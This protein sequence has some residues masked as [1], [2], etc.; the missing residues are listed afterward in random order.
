MKEVWKRFDLSGVKA[1]LETLETFAHCP[2]C[3]KLPETENQHLVTTCRH[4][5]CES[6]FDHNHWTGTCPVL[7]CGETTARRDLRK[8]RSR[9]E[10]LE[11]MKNFKKIVFGDPKN[12]D[13]KGDGV[14]FI[15]SD[16]DMDVDLNDSVV[17]HGFDDMLDIEQGEDGVAIINATTPSSARRES[18]DAKGEGKKSTRI[19][20]TKPKNSQQLMANFLSQTPKNQEKED[21]FTTKPEKKKMSRSVKSK[22]KID[23]ENVLQPSSSLKENEQNADENRIDDKP[24]ETKKRGGRRKSLP[25]ST[26]KKDDNSK[27]NEATETQGDGKPAE[28]KKRGGR[29]KTIPTSTLNKDTDSKEN[30]DIVP[31]SMPLTEP[32]P[33]RRRISGGRKKSAQKKP[34]QKELFKT[35]AESKPTQSVMSA[36]KLNKKN[37]KGETPLHAACC[38][39]DYENAKKFVEQGAETN[40]QD[41]NGWTPLH[42]VAPFSNCFDIVKLLL[43]HGADPNIPGGDLN[44]TP[45]HESSG[46]G[47]SDICQL[48]IKRGADKLARDAHGNTPLDVA[49]NE[50][51]KQM[52]D[53]TEAEITETEQLETTMSLNTSTIPS[54]IILFCH[55]KLSIESTTLIK[56][57][58][59]NLGISLSGDLNEDVTHVLVDLNPETASCPADHVYY[60]SILMGKWILDIE[61]FQASIQA[62]RLIDE[63]DYIADGCH[64]CRTGAPSLAMTNYSNRRP[65]LFEGCHIYLHGKFDGP[66]PD[67]PEVIKMLKRG[68]AFV[69]KREPDPEFIPENE[70]KLPYHIKADSP[71]SKCSHYI[72]YQEGY[73]EPLLK[74]DM[75]HV[76]SL[77]MAWLIECIKNFTIVA[78][79]K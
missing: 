63:I 4:L 19:S 13:K 14:P 49:L 40:T 46:G 36:S 78:P 67:K 6:C 71:L 8:D 29:K 26:L 16:S 75:E 11:G 39:K 32:Q 38:K 52:I 30:D 48:L 25:S 68:G 1:K 31:S 53:D 69:M 28:T 3:K 76:K 73:R 65:K 15:M 62:G 72:I 41:F 59:K 18:K 74:Y 23:P 9:A 58:L 77:P 50:E 33:K 21:I 43:D 7:G 24:A 20:A 10:L 17:M 22:T 35:P 44:T 37:K 34:V 27:E 45:L 2:R 64:D 79:F 70:K 56:S 12:V 5:L 57:N 47:C 51:T 61:W 66:Y 60:E 55:P 54:R 42:E